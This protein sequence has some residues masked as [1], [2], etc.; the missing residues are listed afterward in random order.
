MAQGVDVIVTH[1][2]CNICRT[3]LWAQFCYEQYVITLF[4]STLKAL[5]NKCGSAVLIFLFWTGISTMCVSNKT[6]SKNIF[7][8]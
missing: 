6:N 8:T 3:G 1:L 7:C 5:D 4:Q 2:E